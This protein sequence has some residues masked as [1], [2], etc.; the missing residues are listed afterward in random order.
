MTFAITLIFLIGYVAI[1]GEHPFRINKAAPALL[2]GMLIWSIL[3]IISEDVHITNESFKEHAFDIGNIV[4]F[5]LGAMVVVELM[6][7][8][9]SFGLITS[10]IK[11]KNASTLLIIISVVTFFLSPVLD[12]MTTAI[13]MV[14]VLKKLIH[15]NRTL[16]MK[17][18]GIVIIASNAGG[19]WSPIGDVTTI[20]L[21]IGGQV[22]SKGVISELFLPSFACLMVSVA[23][24]LPSVKEQT[25]GNGD[26]KEMED[27][28]TSLSLFEK[29]IVL[30]LGLLTLLG[31]PVFKSATHLPPFVGIFLG[32]GIM[33][34]V[35]EIIHSR[36]PNYK[37]RTHLVVSS[38][39]RK[40]DVSS[41]LFFLGILFSVA[42][43]QEAGILDR[44]AKLLTATL[45]EEF[46]I[47]GA[48]GI[49]SAI[50]DNVPLVAAVQGMYSLE[51]YNVD[52]TFWNALAYAAGTGGSMLII[53]SAAGVAVM[54]IAK[55][56]FMWYLKR[57]TLPASAGYLAGFFVYYLM[58]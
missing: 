19:A 11:T 41:T 23:F 28:G 47:N 30:S 29:V 48:I 9:D 27:H 18:A 20:M 33:W 34:V 50:V 8:H 51:V 4:F 26:H 38:V 21:W 7:S 57:I 1:I 17:M 12:N 6:D 49:L 35:T 53:G 40:I 2:A 25:I 43:L 42:G 31:V 24:M 39:L 5:L 14:A 15:D 58:S 22:T 56:D 36:H 52:S 55:I 37:E 10:A 45:K 16:F 44:A 54:G 32:L 3:A 46:I 13:V